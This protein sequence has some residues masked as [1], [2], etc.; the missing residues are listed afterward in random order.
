MALIDIDHMRDTAMPLDQPGF[1]LDSYLRQVRDD[2]DFNLEEKLRAWMNDGV[3]VFPK[4]VDSGLIDE[5][6]NDIDVLVSHPDQFELE[7]EVRGARQKLSE[8]ETDLR[9][10]HGVKFNCVENISQAA[11]KLS[12]NP[13]ACQFLRHVFQA[14]PAV[15]QSLTFWRGSG[16]PAH[17]DYP[18][19]RTQTKI[20]HLAASW[21]ALE[22]VDERSG[23]LAYYP[24][25]HNI[26]RIPPFDWGEGSVVL[27]PDSRRTPQEFGPYLKQRLAEQGIAPKVFLPKKGDMLIWHGWVVHEGTKPLDPSFTRKS[28]VSHYTSL[29]AYP[30]GH[31]FPKAMKKKLYTKLNGGY[32]FDKPWVA[33]EKTL[34]SWRN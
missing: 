5:Y 23:P 6:L 32:V 13:S 29:D 10:D 7:V 14:F 33:T 1:S 16:Q 21:I 15:L 19:V 31:Q 4:A 26:D 12:L 24:G 34:P 3:A 8:V 30:P 18:Y 11:R 20:S 17:T 25:S 9:G 28:Y 27:E 2:C 22:D